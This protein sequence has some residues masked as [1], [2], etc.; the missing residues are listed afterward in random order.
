M[1]KKRST[2][3]FILKKCKNMFMQNTTVHYTKYHRKPSKKAW[4]TGCIFLKCTSSVGN[5]E[6]GAE[7]HRQ[8]REDRQYWAIGL[9]QKK[10]N[11]VKYQPH[12][13]KW[14][15]THHEDNDIFYWKSC[16]YQFFVSFLSFK[17]H[18]RSSSMDGFMNYLFS[19]ATIP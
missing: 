19:Q 4:D 5:N 11:T 9:D 16:T 6:L 13:L 12:L 18:L 17:T 14:V 7:S 8:G 3:Y 2:K 15:I 10:K 1:F